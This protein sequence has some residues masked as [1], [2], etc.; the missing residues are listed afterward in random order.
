M[1]RAAFS[2]EYAGLPPIILDSSALLRRFL[3][4]L[5]GLFI[6]ASKLWFTHTHDTP[7]LFSV[8]GRWEFL[9]SRSRKSR[10]PWLWL[11]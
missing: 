10:N 6:L 8:H 9:S 3:M 7:T 11:L 1:E 2:S 5:E 4:Q